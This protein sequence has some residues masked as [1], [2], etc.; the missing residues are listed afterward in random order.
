MDAL[1]IFAA[2]GFAVPEPEYDLARTDGG[3]DEDCEDSV[4]EGAEEEQ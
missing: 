4:R 3:P 2:L 1:D